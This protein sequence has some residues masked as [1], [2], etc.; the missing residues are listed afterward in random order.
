MTTIFLN[1][2]ASLPCTPLGFEIQIHVTIM[3][4]FVMMLGTTPDS[5]VDYVAEFQVPNV[6]GFFGS[7]LRVM[8]E[9]LWNV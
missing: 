7:P 8:L 2:E 9:P 3:L 1:S 4:Q 6:S 5:E